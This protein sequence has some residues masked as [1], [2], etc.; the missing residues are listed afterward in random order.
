MCWLAVFAS[1]CG[2]SDPAENEVD[3]DLLTLCLPFVCGTVDCGPQLGSA[4]SNDSDAAVGYDVNPGTGNLYLSALDIGAAP[5]IGSPIELRRSYNSEGDATNFGFGA[6]WTHTYSWRLTLQDAA[7]ARI[8]TSAGKAIVFTNGPA[9]RAP[10]GEHGTL[11]GNAST[12]FTYTTKHGTQYRFDISKMSGRL[13]S[14]Q[15]PA[16]PTPV[17]ISYVSGTT[18]ASVTS[19]AGYGN[20]GRGSSLVFTYAGADIM[21]IADPNGRVWRYTHDNNDR[22]AQVTRPNGGATMYVMTDVAAGGAVFHANGKITRVQVQTSPG[23]WVDRALF[24][25]DGAPGRVTHAASSA[26][27]GVLQN[28]DSFAY[29]LCSNTASTTVVTLPGGTKTIGSALVAGVQ[30]PTSISATAGAG[31]P[32]ESPSTTFAWNAD[33]TLA[34]V[35]AG[36]ITTAYANYDAKGNP[37][38]ITD[39]AGTP[40]ARMTLLTYHPVL[41]TVMTQSRASIDGAS[42]HVTTYD[43]DADY[44]GTYNAAPT[45]FVHQ[46]IEQ[47]KTDTA[48]SGAA[49]SAVTLVTA[50]YYDAL[51]RP[52]QLVYA[53]GETVGYTYYSAGGAQTA[54][55]RP[56]TRVVGGLVDQVTAYDGDGRVL[57]RTTAAGASIATSYDDLGEVIQSTV[58]AGA[59]S[60]TDQFGYDLA[61]DLVTH[62]GPG[63][64]TV[65]IDYDGAA[66]AYRRRAIATDGTVP[67][68]EVTALDDRGLVVAFRRFVGLGEVA[69][70]VCGVGESAATCASYGYDAFRRRSTFT[71]LSSTD[72]PCAGNDCRITYSYDASGSLASTTEAGLHTTSYGRDGLGRVTTITLPTGGM[73]TLSY[74]VNDQLIGRLDPGNRGASFVWDDFGREIARTTVD[75][76][77]IIANFDGAGLRTH[78]LDARGVRIDASYDAAGRPIAYSVPSDPS[79]NQ[80]LQY[81]Y[82]ETGSVPGGG[83]LVYGFSRGRLTSVI[84]HAADGT[85][86]ATHRS[87][88][89]LGRVTD[90]IDER[91]G[92]IAAQHYAYG[93]DGELVGETYPS[94][95]QVSFQFPAT[96]RFAPVPRAT[97]ATV[98]F[99]AGTQTLFDTATY[100]HDGALESLRYANGT[101]RQLTRNKRGEVTHLVAGPWVDDRFDYDA[102]GR[103]RLAAVHHFEGAYNASD[104]TYTRDALNRVTSTTTTDGDSSTT[105]SWTYDAVGNRLSQTRDGVLTAYHY[106]RGNNRLASLTG[107]KADSWTYDASGFV[108]SHGSNGKLV[109]YTYDAQS[110][111]VQLQ[112]QTSAPGPEA[113]PLSV[114]FTYLATASS[115][116]TIRF[117]I[118]G[119]LAAVDTADATNSC[120][121]GIRT[122]VVTDPVIVGL[123]ST[124]QNGLSVQYPGSLAWAVATING[125]DTV[126]FD[127][128]TQGDAAARNPDL[129][130]AG[131]TSDGAVHSSIRPG[132][133]TAIITYTYDTHGRVW[134][135]RQSDGRYRR[136]YYDARGRIAE[137]KEFRGEMVNGDQKTYVVDFVRAGGDVVALLTRICSRPDVGVPQQCI[138]VDLQVVTT[139]MQGPANIASAVNPGL[140]W[141]TN[142]DPLGNWSDLGS[143][144]GVDGQL[145]TG[146]DTP[147]TLTNTIDSLGDTHADPFD[148]LIDFGQG[149]GSAFETDQQRLGG[150]SFDTAWDGSSYSQNSIG[151]ALTMFGTRGGA[152]GP[153]LAPNR[154]SLVG[155]D[156]DDPAKL[157]EDEGEGKEC[158]SCSAPPLVTAEGNPAP[159]GDGPLTPNLVPNDQPNQAF[160]TGAGSP[161]SQTTASKV[162]GALQ[163]DRDKVN[164]PG[165][166]DLGGVRGSVVPKGA[167]NDPGVVN[168]GVDP[169]NLLCADQADGDGCGSDLTPAAVG[170]PNITTGWATHPIN[171]GDADNGPLQMSDKKPGYIDYVDYVPPLPFDTSTFNPGNG[172]CA[173]ST[174]G[175]GPM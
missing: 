109:G 18:I 137:E 100:G 117:S 123:L 23:V 71:T 174:N 170:S 138:D 83:D 76:G 162:I 151:D 25:Y 60:S 38:T 6:G 120:T 68:S 158:A 55:F 160:N 3:N 122:I 152:T 54:S 81:V 129:C 79:G 78:T 5:A 14:I 131:T 93:A 84:A 105:T 95:K 145:G 155:D 35:T 132:A 168:P 110:R 124:G 127:A 36:S 64:N 101:T 121:P 40:A 106:L 118:N 48:L 96:G 139:N 9:W 133:G 39:G 13:L 161:Q 175:C 98:P 62:I 146:D 107:G 154:M 77:R 165:G 19:G 134:E 167:Y 135:R 142:T 169:N 97:S 52:T 103:G 41:A 80:N 114:T 51:S 45:N 57:G 50:Y 27:G 112:E 102:N 47:G 164:Q 140:Q 7:T 43:Y 115:P 63:G 119:T 92:E 88:D 125:T 26:L 87:Y 156:D 94:G 15:E 173:H 108:A 144:P 69:S 24:S 91:G 1:A 113:P 163:G 89:V 128:G 153:T 58:S 141:D 86:I 159:T 66:R 2:A 70:P 73:T 34:S 61:G 16:S 72:T 104:W 21:S 143:Q 147:M 8:T 46:V 74:D 10:V 4:S 99:G 33:L 171:P 12:G 17:T 157:K 172:D 82:D 59:S 126:I 42:Q 116:Q 20:A 166:V 32:G 90:A 150:P 65:Q 29:T 49:S 37:R 67:W 130:A 136:T 11:V 31:V 75:A 53:N 22:L 28:E 30:R 85:R 148:G 111:L 44:D 56:A 149:Q